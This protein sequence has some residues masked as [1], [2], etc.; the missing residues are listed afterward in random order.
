MWE[1]LLRSR[2][3]MESFQYLK[4]INKLVVLL[5][6]LCNITVF[7]GLIRVVDL[8]KH[9]AQLVAF[10]INVFEFVQYFLRLSV[11]VVIWKFNTWALTIMLLTLK[12]KFIL[13]LRVSYKIK[14]PKF[15]LLRSVCQAFHQWHLRFRLFLVGRPAT[16]KT[17]LPPLDLHRTRL[18]CLFQSIQLQAGYPILQSVYIKKSLWTRSV[19]TT[20][21]ISSCGIVNFHKLN[22]VFVAIIV[23]VF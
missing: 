20:I 18:V 5:T 2:L 6:G 1:Y 16:A 23:D 19:N 3:A 14:R 12:L 10:V 15:F 4:S 13:L 22:S 9:Y 11:I 7:F 8:N 17:H 21:F